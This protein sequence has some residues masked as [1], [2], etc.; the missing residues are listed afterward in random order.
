[1]STALSL[2]T[3]VAIPRL[4]PLQKWRAPKKNVPQTLAER[5]SILRSVRNYVAEYNPVPPLPAAELKVLADRLVDR[6][7]CDP[8]YRDY[9][10]VLI[11]N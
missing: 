11:N 5:T 10:G 9:I 7:G 3:P 6:L 1:M 4:A 2:N 8:I